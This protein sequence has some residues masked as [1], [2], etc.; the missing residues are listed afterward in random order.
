MNF[1]KRKPDNFNYDQTRTCQSCQ[2]IFAGRY[3]SRCGEKVIEPE[4]RSFKQFANGVFNA[5][6][7]ID[8]KF[9][10]SLKLLILHPG[11]FAQRMVTGIRQPYM[12]PIALFFVANFVYFLFPLFQTFNTTLHSQMNYMGYNEYAQTRVQRHLDRT[13]Q[14]LE[15]FTPIYNRTSTN[16]SKLLLILM[17][18]LFFPFAVLINLN[19]RSY[20]SDHLMFSLEFI[21]YVLFVPTILLSLL[22]FLI[23]GAGQLFNL[24]F[25]FLF[26]DGTITPILLGLLL[27]FFIRSLRA[28]YG[29]PWWRTVINS[30]LFLLATQLTLS[31]Y[32]FIL[33]QV[34]LWD[35]IR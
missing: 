9:F 24:H 23:A 32:R 28:F 22:L 33:F 18:L 3:C 8:G 6:T 25:D 27:Y 2:T 15:N 26:W 16:W 19:K 1:L 12:K 10:N 35:L 20:L 4:D 13:G 11:R 29:F 34:T 17:V 14:S 7:F 5:Y 21:T 31:A 30:V